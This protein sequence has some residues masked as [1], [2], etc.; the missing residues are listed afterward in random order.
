[1]YWNWNSGFRKPYKRRLT[2]TW[3]VLKSR[4]GSYS[5]SPAERLT[6]T[7]DVLKWMT[8]YP[9]IHICYPIN[10]NMRCIEIS[11]KKQNNSR[12]LD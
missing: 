1:M 3:D 4:Y 8:E 6:L 10:I 11:Y 5:E 7:W 12:C 9:I 2:L